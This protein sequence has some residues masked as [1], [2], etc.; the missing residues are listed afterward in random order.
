MNRGELRTLTS[1][2]CEDPNI[3]KFSADKYN[4]SL[5]KAQLQFALDSKALYKDQAITMVAGTASYALG[6][7]FMLEKE[8]VLNGI[9][10]KPIS[11]ATL[12]AKKTDDRW[13]DDSGTPMW[14]VIDPE[15]ARKTIT[16]YPKPDSEAEGTSLVLTYYP[17]PTAM[18]ADSDTPLNSS[19][20]MTQFHMALANYAAWL[21]MLYLPQTPEIAQKRAE[22]FNIYLAKVTE[23]IQTF[24]NTRS[25]PMSFHVENVRAR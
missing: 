17:T 14:Y 20:L 3:T 25:E 16:L 1:R 5:E 24:G 23:A 8:V 6:S 13:D 9:A 12:Q 15:E 11:R 22:F 21:L 19:S 7:D 2:L 10:L 18:T 4:D